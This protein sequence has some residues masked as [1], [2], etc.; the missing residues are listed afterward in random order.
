MDRVVYAIISLKMGLCS[1]NSK[2]IS[3]ELQNFALQTSGYVWFP[4]FPSC[5]I[6]WILNTLHQTSVVLR[7]VNS[8]MDEVVGYTCKRNERSKSL[9][10]FLSTNK[11]SKSFFFNFE[12]AH[13]HATSF[14]GNEVALSRC[15]FFR[16]TVGTGVGWASVIVTTLWSARVILIGQKQSGIFGHTTNY[17]IVSFWVGWVVH[18]ALPKGREGEGIIGS[19]S[20]SLRKGECLKYETR[21]TTVFGD[22]FWNFE[23]HKDELYC[24]C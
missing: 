17:Q 9:P 21:Q 2:V 19:F 22:I 11:R 23:V 8:R 13:C 12:S 4:T 16:A 7:M 1:K 5:N 18:Y 10:E 20:V 14:P 6:S 15:L 3:R 24:S